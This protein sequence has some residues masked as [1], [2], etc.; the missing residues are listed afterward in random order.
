[1]AIS[2]VFTTLSRSATISLKRDQSGSTGNAGAIREAGGAF[3]KM[4]AAKEAEYFYKK[5]RSPFE[6]TIHRF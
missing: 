3:G 5:V 2:Y 6:F 1:M 4:G